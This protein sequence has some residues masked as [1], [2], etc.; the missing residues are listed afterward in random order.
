MRSVDDIVAA[1]LRWL[2]ASHGAYPS[3]SESM[4]ARQLHA[5]QLFEALTHGP[6]DD[7]TLMEIL[8]ECTETGD[9]RA[10]RLVGHLLQLDDDK[11]ERVIESIAA[12]LPQ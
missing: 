5:P 7:D 3:A 4:R 1:A 12:S 8:E 2:A 6:L 10:S 11:R 9:S